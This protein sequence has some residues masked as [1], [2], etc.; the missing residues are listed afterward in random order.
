MKIWKFDFEGNEKF[1]ILNKCNLLRNVLD[2]V[3]IDNSIQ[4]FMIGFEQ[5]DLQ[6]FTQSYDENEDKYVWCKT[7]N[8]KDHEKG[9]SCMEV[10]DREQFIITGCDGG[11]V[12]IWNCLKQMIRAIRFP[13]KINAVSFLNS[14]GDILVAHGNNISYIFA[15]DY[16]F[17]KYCKAT[18][19]KEFNKMVATCQR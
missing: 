1:T 12:K 19:G 2:I 6:L 17:K 8:Y 9:L 7:E 15:K 18:M 11:V 3:V 5:S 14:N 10:Y 16:G 4:M 13:D